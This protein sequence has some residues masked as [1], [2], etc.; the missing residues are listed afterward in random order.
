MVKSA[1]VGIWAISFEWSVPPYHVLPGRRRVN[2]DVEHRVGV[3]RKCLPERCERGSLAVQ[4]IHPIVS[5]QRSADVPGEDIGAIRPVRGGYGKCAAFDALLPGVVS[6]SL[7]QEGPQHV[8]PLVFLVFDAPQVGNPQLE[9]GCS[10]VG[11]G[12][13]VSVP[14]DELKVVVLVVKRI[15]VVEIVHVELVHGDRADEDHP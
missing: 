11:V 8:D 10:L 4:N 5:E 7:P 3:F 6:V 12:Y 14:V 15:G 13:P 2:L 9:I 1:P